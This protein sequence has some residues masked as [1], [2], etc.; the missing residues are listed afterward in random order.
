[1]DNGIGTMYADVPKDVIVCA[2]T[3][4]YLVDNH[5]YDIDP[6]IDFTIERTTKRKMNILDIPAKS[7]HR[8]QLDREGVATGRPL[9]PERIIAP[10]PSK[11]VQAYSHFTTTNKSREL[12]IDTLSRRLAYAHLDSSDESEF[13]SDSD[14]PT[15]QPSSHTSSSDDESDR[16]R[17]KYSSN[18]SDGGSSRGLSPI[19]PLDDGSDRGSPP[20]DICYCHKYGITRSGQRLKIDCHGKDCHFRP[21]PLPS[22]R[23][24]DFRDSRARIEERKPSSSY[25]DSRYDGKSSRR[26]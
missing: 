7:S 13:A 6:D 20:V 16:E 14:S 23:K 3:F 9:S 1:V 4:Q 22:I 17:G 19:T 12:A 2:N 25:R 24:D 8:Q 15:D 21:L 18:S 5:K 11:P 10:R 26:R